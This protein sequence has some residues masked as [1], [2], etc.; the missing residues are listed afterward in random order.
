MSGEGPQM[1]IPTTFRLTGEEPQPEPMLQPKLHPQ[2]QPMLHPQ[3]Q[4]MLHPQLQPILQPQLQ[5]MLQPRIQPQL[6]PQL[7]QLQPQLQPMKSTS[8]SE[9]EGSNRIP[10]QESDLDQDVLAFKVDVEGDLNS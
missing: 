7:Q 8:I 9:D 1:S 2:L 6:Q 3:L 10:I 5:P 4:P